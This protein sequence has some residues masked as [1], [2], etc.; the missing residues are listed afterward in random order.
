MLE[1]HRWAS[2]TAEARPRVSL[3]HTRTSRSRRICRIL[4]MGA[5]LVLCS[6]VLGTM[7][8]LATGSVTQAPILKLSGTT[9]TWSAISGVSSYE[10]ATVRHPTT[11]RNTT[12]QVVSGTSLKP[13]AVPG[14]A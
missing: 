13:P 6:A 11:T 3:Q 4:H 8:P 14:E 9:L 2:A 1:H 7:A 10:V 12:Y 5:T